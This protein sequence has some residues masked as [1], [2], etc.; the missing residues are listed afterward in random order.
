MGAK[1]GLPISGAMDMRSFTW[2]NH[3]LQNDPSDA[4][5]EISQPGFSIQVEASTLIS[6][7]G[8]KA[9]VLVNS[10]LEKNSSLI[11]LE[12]GDKL[13]IGQFLSGSRV[14]LGIK[15]G[16]Q[17]AEWLNSRSFFAPL[18]GQS[19]LKKG[20]LLSFPTLESPSLSWNQAK[21]RW[22]SSWYENPKIEA[23]KGP[24]WALLTSEQ[25]ELILKTVF[26]VSKLSNRMGIQLEELVENR[27]P[28][29]P[30]NPVFPGTVQLTSGGKLLILMK[31][32]GVTGGY[33]RILQL[34][35]NSI[36]QLAQ[37]NP[38]NAIH[39]VLKDF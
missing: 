32:A 27:L 5:L 36:S 22:N 33:P 7:S 3:V 23:F 13:E 38:G 26:H 16:F 8:A 24:D 21:P 19:I 2:V 29:L 15:G 31:D 17:S 1:F 4:V 9:I 12:K 34:P 10:K 6:I 25:Q 37:K 35:E 11:S 39:W 30:T 18:T 14:Y 28:E 20:E